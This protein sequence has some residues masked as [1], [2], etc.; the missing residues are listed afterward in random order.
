AL[1]ALERIASHLE[2]HGAALV[3]LFTPTPTPEDQ[4]G[5][6]RDH[7]TDDGSVQRVSAVSET[8]DEE[9]RLQTTVLRYES[10]Q[11]G[12]TEV[13][14][15]PWAIH[16]RTERGFADL[17]TAAGLA[18]TAIRQSAFILAPAAT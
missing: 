8:R 10:T 1:A 6:T 11:D 9:R 7:V 4:L 18:V 15:R 17:A 5:V 16:W 2:P 3:P 13:L 14:D 12:V